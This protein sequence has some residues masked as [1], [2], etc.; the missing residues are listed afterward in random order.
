MARARLRTLSV[1]LLSGVF[2]LTGCGT[3]ATTPGSGPT[4]STGAAVSTPGATSAGGTLTGRSAGFTVGAPQ[5]WTEA[6][7]QAAGVSG[8]DLVVLSSDKV[9]GFSNNVVVLSMAGDAASLD[10]KLAEG[11]S[12]MTGAGRTV[13]DLPD[14]TVA[15][16]PGRGFATSFDQQ[17]IQVLA[18]SY[19][20]QHS[21]KVYLLTLSSSQEDADHAAQEFQA[22][23]ATWKWA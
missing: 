18:R 5:G 22:M 17:G 1:I 4:G 13:S 16:E 8:I 7:D 20:V 6:T 10:G 14:I 15:G 12:Q 9:A 3:P 2:V 11:R 23:L 19:G 21:G